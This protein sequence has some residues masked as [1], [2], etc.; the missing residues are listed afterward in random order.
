VT[1]S[2]K[3]ILYADEVTVGEPGTKLNM[4]EIVVISIMNT[5]LGFGAP[6]SM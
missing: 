5:P 3:E 2:S 6:F 1:E 4:Y